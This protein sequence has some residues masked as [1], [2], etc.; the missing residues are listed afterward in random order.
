[1][2]SVGERVRVF[3]DDCPLDGMIVFASDNRRSLAVDLGFERFALLAETDENV[4]AGR[5]HDI[6]TGRHCRVEFGRV[7]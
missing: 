5:Y 3:I 6:L 4:A 1:M 2:A 7:L